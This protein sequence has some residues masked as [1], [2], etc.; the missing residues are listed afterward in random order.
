MELLF[1]SGDS[2]IIVVDPT[3]GESTLKRK[4]LFAHVQNAACP[5]PPRAG[6]FPHTI[7]RS[8]SVLRTGCTRLELLGDGW[9]PWPKLLGRRQLTETESALWRLP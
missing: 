8:Q 3:D 9:H 6:H 1:S 5:G 2:L 4:G 7:V